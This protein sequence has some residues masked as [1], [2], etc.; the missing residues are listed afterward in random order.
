MKPI[1]A[2]VGRPNVGKSTLFN[3]ITKSRN[4]LVDDIPGVTRD[5]NYGDGEWNGIAFTVVD[6]GGF[7]PEDADPFAGQIQFQVRQ[8]IQDADAVLLLLDGI[9]GVSPFDRELVEQVRGLD[10]PVFFAVNKIDGPEKEPDLFEFHALGID[11]LHPLSAAHRYGLNDLLDNLVSALPRVTAPDSADRIHVAVVG[12]PNVGKSSLINSLSGQERLVVSDV[13]GT[14]RDAVDT[15]VKVDG[16]T[17]RF[18]DTAGIRR[19]SRV[20]RRLEKFSVIKALRSLDRCDVALIVIDAAEGITDQDIT[21][22][23]YAHQRRCGCIFLLNKWD[24]VEKDTHSVNRFSERV[25]TRARFLHFAP[26]LTLSAKTQLRTMRIFGIV[27]RVYAQ[28][29]SRIPTGEVNRILER[30]V[31]RKSPPLHKGKRLKFYYATQVTARPPTFVFF[32]NYPEAVH[33]SYQR[34]LV[35]RLREEAGLDETPVRAL[36]RLR[37]GRIAFDGRKS[38]GAR[39]KSGSRRRKKS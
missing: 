21:I 12:R 27:D 20:S 37:T 6:T 30:A 29:A 19:K 31:Q 4:A 10:K 9:S 5:R 34:Y 13:P 33:F 22:A 2:I 7:L 35:N 18:V 8:A 16:Q 14:T 26:V 3:R 23:G 24:L 32:V 15:E 25:R 28:Y 36:F 38:G 1:V 17:Y 11:A 39:Q